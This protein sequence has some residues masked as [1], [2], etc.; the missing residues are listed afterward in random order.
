M[1]FV[2]KY[3][4]KPWKWGKNGLSGNPSI[5]MEFVEKHI[6]K[7]WCLSSNPSITM[8]FVEKYI[9][10]Q[11]LSGWIWGE[12]GLSSNPSITMEFVE[13]HIDKPWSWGRRGLSNNPSITMEFIEKHIDPSQAKACFGL[14]KPWDWCEYGLSSNTFS[15][16]LKRER[17]DHAARVIQNACHDL[18]WAP[19]H[20]GILVSRMLRELNK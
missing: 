16:E 4:D 3:I 6:D 1:E 12:D 8:G 11:G 19:N 18:L 2:E 7:P 15:Y 13:K 14:D 9:Y 17:E 20:N 10:K 5:T